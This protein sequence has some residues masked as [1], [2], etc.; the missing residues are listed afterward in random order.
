MNPKVALSVAFAAGL[1]V[2]VSCG[3]SG[4]S[5]FNGGDAGMGHN[6]S[7]GSGG[8]AGIQFEGG[9][10]TSGSGGGGGSLTCA[11]AAMS[12]SYIGCDYWPTV[13]ANSVWSVFDFTVV[14][15]NTQSVTAN[16]TVTGPGGVN[17][18]VSVAPGQLTKIYLP[19][20][21]ALKG[22]DCDS[23]GS[24]VAM[25][26]SVT[27]PGS[28]YHLVSSSPVTV[29]QFNAL[30]Y[31]GMGGPPGKDW[32]SCPGNTVCPSIR[33]AVGCY[34]FTNDASLLLP[35]TAMTGNYRV[36]GEHSSTGMGS[37]AVVTATEDSTTVTVTLSSTAKVLA[38]PGVAPTGPGGILNF[39][40]NKGDVVELMGGLAQ[41]DDLSGSL[42]QANN[43]IQVISGIQ[44]TVEPLTA[45]DATNPPPACDHLESVLL[46]AETLGKDYVVTMPTSPGGA[47][48]VGK[49]RVVGNVDGTTLT[50][51][52]SQPP[53]CPSTL[54]AGQV[55]ECTGTPSCS[56]T[57]YTGI[58][59]TTNCLTESFQVTGTSEFEVI[60]LMLGGSIIDSTATTGKQLGDPSMSPMV[61]TQQYRSRYIFLAPT[62][63]TESYADVVAPP[64]TTLTLDGTTVSAAATPVNS[65]YSVSRIP[66]GAGNDGA[67]VLTG[68]NPFGVQVIGYGDYTSYQ[69]PA[70]L[71]LNQI[72]PP[73]PPPK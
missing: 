43:P 6:G 72:A 55:V 8:T 61:T 63:Y 30:E 69:Y 71:D 24:T 3:G 26:G 54:D 68:T 23:C 20:V 36:V 44:C 40:L 10:G 18:M 11:Q 15:A 57:G 21:S 34:S 58:K 67:H 56:Y 7:A 35:S 22:K 60:T 37:Y 73:P 70:G 50:Y 64:G 38:G 17:Q 32:S 46:P 27:A 1:A 33:M 53:G 5:G 59:G 47:A 25:T 12:K 16:V 48:G 49:V 4:K 42:V 66:L 28:A 65:A 41:T 62:D 52:P 39:G 45:S 19:W 29:Y 51:S 14:V 2:S 13:A 31:V 9:G